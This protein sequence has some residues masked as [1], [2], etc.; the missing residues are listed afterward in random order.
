M[1]EEAGVV[2][3]RGVSKRFGEVTAVAGVDLRVESGE[4]LTL[5]G[6]SGCGKTTVL[7][8]ISGFETPTAG[9]VL[10]DGRDVTALPPYRRD[11]NQVFQSYALFP[12]LSVRGNVEFG[13]RMKRVPRRERDRRVDEAIALVSLGGLESRKPDQLSGGQKQR[14]ALARALVCQ[15]RVLLLDEPLAALDAKLR[16]AMQIE[17]K[18]L[19]SRVGITFVFVTHDQEEALVMSDR[20]AVMNRGRVEQIANA[21]EIYHKPATAFVAD[22]LGQANVLDA[23]LIQI[24]GEYAELMIAGTINLRV[25]RTSLPQDNRVGFVSIRPERIRIIQSATTGR[26]GISG[27]IRESVFRGASKQLLIE[28]KLSRPLHAIRIA[29]SDD[30]AA[31]PGEHV[32]CE[33]DPDDVVVLPPGE[34]AVPDTAHVR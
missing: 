26:N 21:A 7:R 23:K 9:S 1:A 17:L 31:A 13:L 33:I 19:Q 6:P 16:R 34:G 20:I 5:L 22:F 32:F 4:F 25:L 3:L 18:R 24:E 15:P 10:L 29:D 12:H 11:V 8:M 30:R 2:E 14:V 28:T 27:Q